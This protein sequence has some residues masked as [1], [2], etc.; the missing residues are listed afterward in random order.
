MPSPS[1]RS[2]LPP[3]SR[4]ALLG[5]ELGDGLGHVQQLAR[6]A[7]ALAAQGL[8]PALAVKN[9]A[10]AGA[11][12]RD[13]PYPLLQAPYW[14]PRPWTGSQPF[15]ATSYAD[16]LAIRGFAD[17]ADL[18]PMVQAWQGLL[19]LVRP[20]LVVCDHS[21]TLCLAAYRTLPT[22][23]LGH[24][25]GLPPADGPTFPSLIPERPA[26]VPEEQL[27]SAVREVQRRRGRPASE[28]LPGLFAAAERFLT[29]LPELDPYRPLRHEPHLGPLDFGLGQPLPPPQRASFFAYL[30]ADVPCAEQLV[31]GLARAGIPGVVHLRGATPEARQRLR[32]TG[33]EILDA[34]APVEEVLPRVAV[35]VHHGGAGLAQ[36]ALAAGRPQ[37]FFPDHLERI[38]NAR[39]VEQLGAGLY[40][41]GQFPAEAVPQALRRLTEEPNFTERAQTA[42][43]AVA[44]R[45]PWDPLPR[46]VERCLSLVETAP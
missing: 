1:A 26:V 44:E 24:A 33:L 40:L 34:P 20:A 16:I 14:H 31:Q 6:L 3:P 21:P 22:V 11:A 17:P 7:R 28:T 4:T 30:S 8:Q 41:S 29:F 46:I 35:V 42:A 36:Q 5:W 27:L 15:L 13:L 10:R 38:L 12:F 23:I 45:G 25:F 2:G 37:L 39:L 9:L 19:D 18:L 43:R 32:R